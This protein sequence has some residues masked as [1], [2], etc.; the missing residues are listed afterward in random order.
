MTKLIS[1]QKQRSFFQTICVLG[2]CVCP[3]N[4]GALLIVAM[5]EII[6]VWAKIMVTLFFMTWSVLCTYF[7]KIIYQKII[8]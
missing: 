2:Y 7:F 1:F 8:H 4:I 6:P 3:L 5:K